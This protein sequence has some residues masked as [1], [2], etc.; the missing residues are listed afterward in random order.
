ML[1]KFILI[2]TNERIYNVNF[3]EK[4]II[5]SFLKNFICIFL[6]FIALK[7]ISQDVVYT[8]TFGSPI[9]L[10]PAFAGNLAKTSFYL[11]ARQQWQQAESG[12][13]TSSFIADHHLNNLNS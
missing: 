4:I 3:V 12:Y 8:Q 9:Y 10:N 11:N 1:F 7:T 13:I 5:T 6:I 2:N